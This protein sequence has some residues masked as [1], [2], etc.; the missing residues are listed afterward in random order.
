MARE[1]GVHTQ[2]H[3]H[4][5]R[6]KFFKELY[7]TVGEDFCQVYDEKA[8]ERSRKLRAARW[9]TALKSRESRYLEL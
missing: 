1:M 3:D 4:A 6:T 9:K 2:S 7:E 8:L 5:D